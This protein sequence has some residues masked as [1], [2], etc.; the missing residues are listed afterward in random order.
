MLYVPFEVS[1]TELMQEELQAVLDELRDHQRHLDI[2]KTP[3]VYITQKSNPDEVQKWL[4]AKGF[5]EKIRRQ[6]NTMNG[7][8]ILA[9]K[10]HQLVQICGRSEGTRLDS[11]LTIQRN[12]SGYKTA[13]STELRAILARARRKA[14]GSRRESEEILSPEV[15]NN[16]DHQN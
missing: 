4:E 5:N 13:R 6:F 1:H 14:E 10:R 7:N 11:Q 16:K 8:E 2:L 12:V 9:L 15:A 3:E